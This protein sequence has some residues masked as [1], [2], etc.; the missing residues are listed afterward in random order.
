MLNNVFKNWVLYKEQKLLWN[1]IADL[2]Q[3]IP[4]P[5]LYEHT[6]LFFYAG[7]LTG[8]W[9]ADFLKPCGLSLLTVT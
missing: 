7:I 9:D 1:Q 3:C 6:I 2:T 4:D 5:Y 8:P